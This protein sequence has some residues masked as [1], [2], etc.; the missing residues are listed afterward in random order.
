MDKLCEATPTRNHVTRGYVASTPATPSQAAQELSTEG[1]GTP[2]QDSPHTEDGC[3][4]HL[5][6]NVDVMIR[7][8][9]VDFLFNVDILGLIDQYL[10]IY[11]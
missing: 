4:K 1:G 11:R 3:R 5:E 7:L 6:N 2:P 10:C 8:A 9:F